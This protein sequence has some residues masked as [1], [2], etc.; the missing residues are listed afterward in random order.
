M[1]P[2]V[3]YVL[4]G[5][6]LALLACDDEASGAPPAD[7]NQPTTSASAQA[8]GSPKIVAAAPVFEFGKVKL[9]ATVEHVFKVKNAGTGPLEIT[10]AKGS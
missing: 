8:A 7:S 6:P 2:F 4:L 1:K 10:R 9:G 3:Y 5:L